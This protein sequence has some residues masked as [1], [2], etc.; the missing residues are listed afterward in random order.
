MIQ[1]TRSHDHTRRTAFGEPPRFESAEH[2]LQHYYD[3]TE[4]GNLPW[5]PTTRDELLLADE[6]GL[7]ETSLALDSVTDRTAIAEPA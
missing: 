5:P 6:V 7:L 4:C 2:W 1:A 3:F